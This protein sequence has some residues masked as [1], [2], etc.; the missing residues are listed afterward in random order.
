VYRYR[1]VVDNSPF[2]IYRVTYD[3]RFTTVNPALCA[4]VGYTAE[5]LLESNIVTLYPSAAERQMWLEEFQNRPIGKP[6]DVAWRHKSGKPITARVWVYAER[7]PSGAIAY[8]DGYVEDVTPIR[9][10]E[11]ALRQSEKLAALG[12]L[13][14]GVAHELNNPLAAILLF[15]EDLLASDRPAEEREALNVIAQQARRSRAIVRD[16]LSFARHRAATRA[17]VALDALLNDLART[18]QPQIAEL[19]VKLHLEVPGTSEILDIEREGIEQVITNLVMNAA[20]AAG[21]GGDVW[22]RARAEPD[23]YVFQVVDNGPGIANE[24]L[25]RIFEPFF[26]TKPSGQGT[27]LG[28]SVS[29]GIA[30]Q[31]GGTIVAGNRDSGDGSGA[32]FNLRL[33]RTIAREGAGPE[34]VAPVRAAAPAQRPGADQ[35]RVLIIDDEANIRRALSR[36]YVRRGWIP[37]EASDGAAA[38][39]RLI[40]ALEDFDLILSDVKMP[41]MS[42][43][44]LHAALLEKRPEMLDRLVFCTGDMQSPVVI[45][46]AGQTTCRF[47]LKPFDL[48]TL[49]LL[50]DE[51]AAGPPIVA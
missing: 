34:V 42:G 24:T 10:T 23:W 26:T 41:N 17:P 22:L 50:S 6:V 13:V 44:E 40:G 46:F 21:A 19:S 11:L 51:I 31:H 7:D 2:G 30:E 25:P 16:L 15:T 20:Q 39:Q 5:E 8:F 36:F 43:I 28:L 33:P 12:Q 38:M 3:G 32:C 18:L 1:L 9:A 4:I 29:L 48:H 45:D 37:A 47:L 27:G 49:G 35:R 14:S